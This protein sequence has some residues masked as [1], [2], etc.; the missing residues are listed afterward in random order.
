MSEILNKYREFTANLS[1]GVRLIAVSKTKPAEEI[2]SLYN[3]G[4]RDFGENKVQELVKKAETLPDDIRWH[5]VGHLQTNKI[6]YIAPFITLIHSVDRL[7]LLRAIEK[8]GKKNDRVLECLLQVHIAKEES[9][10]GFSGEELLDLVNSGDLE[11]FDFV[12][13]RGLMGMA[14][15]TDNMEQIRAEFRGLKAIFDQVSELEKPAFNSFD[16]L[17]IGMSNDYR[18]AIEEGA[19]MIRIGSQI[20][21]ERNYH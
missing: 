8:E 2:L 15:F 16:T 21:G 12:H 9:K 10:F 14:T 4:Q 5:M 13:I 18:L 3:E 7:K 11:K 20:F 19:T 1:G 17:S 6:K